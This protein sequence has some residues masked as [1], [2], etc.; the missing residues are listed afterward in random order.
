MHTTYINR[1]NTTLFNAEQ[2][3]AWAT[4]ALE[5]RKGQDIQALDV[6][7]QTDFTDF[8]IIAT[9]TSDRHV[10]S[11]ADAVVEKVKSHGM[12]PYG[13][14]GDDKSGWMLVDLGDVIVHLMRAE[15]REYYNLEKL[16]SAIDAM[17]T[18]QPSP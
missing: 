17:R 13:A 7:G 8:M 12:R 9:G 2:I 11:L 16:W 4:E 10:S 5:D 1:S 6:R 3:K 18:R 14:E 15:T